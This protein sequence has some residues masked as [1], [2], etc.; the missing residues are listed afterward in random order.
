MKYYII[1][2]GGTG[3]AIGYYMTKAG[4]DVCL[5]AR[6]E[7]LKAMRRNGLTIRHNG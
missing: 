1:G 3:G 7:H 4:K 6:G 5:L 2:A